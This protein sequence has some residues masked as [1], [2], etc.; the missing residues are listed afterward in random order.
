[1]ICKLVLVI[2]NTHSHVLVNIK[3]SDKHPSDY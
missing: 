1:M 2:I 3:N